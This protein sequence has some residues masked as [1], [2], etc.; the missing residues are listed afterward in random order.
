[1]TIGGDKVHPT[2]S[3]T[4]QMEYMLAF[5][6][7]LNQYIQYKSMCNNINLSS[8]Y[9]MATTHYL[10]S[11][12]KQIFSPTMP[13]F[14]PITY[15]SIP[16]PPVY[17]SSLI[18]EIS[19]RKGNAWRNCLLLHTPMKHSIYESITMKP[20]IL[21]SPSSFPNSSFNNF[22]MWQWAASMSVIRILRYR[23]HSIWI[24][25]IFVM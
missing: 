1:M 6:A 21:I 4:S 13:I 23:C 8:N 19:H 24:P 15:M 12:T 25:W 16:C 2:P 20:S 10:Y 18:E 5:R 22:Q 14:T 9:Q 17:N 3:R 7:E 11:R